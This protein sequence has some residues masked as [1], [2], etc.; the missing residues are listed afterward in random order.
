MVR[1][2]ISDTVKQKPAWGRSDIKLDCIPPRCLGGYSGYYCE[3]VGIVFYFEI[4]IHGRSHYRTQSMPEDP[5]GP[6]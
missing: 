3:V 4:E 6:P 5:W 2:E 1:I